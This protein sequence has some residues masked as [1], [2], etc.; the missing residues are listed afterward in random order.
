VVFGLGLNPVKKENSDS[1][2]DVDLN[3]QLIYKGEGITVYAE[4]FKDQENIL[5]LIVENK[6]DYPVSV[7]DGLN[8]RLLLQHI[9]L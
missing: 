3:R 4:G 2:Y 9:V 6:N 7:Y 8:M 5:T 1:N